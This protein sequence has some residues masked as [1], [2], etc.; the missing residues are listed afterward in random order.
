MQQ[1]CG[2]VETGHQF[3]HSAL[4]VGEEISTNGTSEKGPTTIRYQGLDKYHGAEQGQRRHLC[5][6]G[7]AVWPDQKSN[8]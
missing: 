5:R 7:L 2:D 8:F 4:K 6:D 3:K 1:N